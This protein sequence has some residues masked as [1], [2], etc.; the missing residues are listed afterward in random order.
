MTC[1]RQIYFEPIGVFAGRIS[2]EVADE[3]TFSPYC[4]AEGQAVW[5]EKGG[6]PFDTVSLVEVGL[7]RLLDF[8]SQIAIGEIPKYWPLK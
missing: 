3:F 1:R 8:A 6:A 2:P 5:R 7:E 4:T